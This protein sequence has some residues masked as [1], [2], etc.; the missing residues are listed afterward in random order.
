MK[1]TYYVYILSSKKNGVLYIGVTNNLLRRVYEHKKKLI[2]GFTTKYFVNKL[3]YFEETDSIYSAI[4]REKQLKKWYRK[5]KIELIE[6]VNPEWK[7]LY[8]EYGGLDEYEDIDSFYGEDS[9][10]SLSRT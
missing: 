5:W 4:Q 9:R 2:T 1:N 3:V 8:Y 7:D 10:W 6:R